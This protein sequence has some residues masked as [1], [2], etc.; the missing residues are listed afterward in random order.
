MVPV[1]RALDELTQFLQ[2]RSIPRIAERQ[3]IAAWYGHNESIRRQMRKCVVPKPIDQHGGGFKISSTEDRE[4]V[5]VRLNL[6]V[7]LFE[8]GTQGRDALLMQFGL[9]KSGA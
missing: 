1:L 6:D 8:K 3:D 5:S 2:P 9:S 7:L 4:H